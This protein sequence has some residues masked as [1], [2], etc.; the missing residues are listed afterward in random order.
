MKQQKSI[1]GIALRYGSY[2]LI[3]T[4]VVLAVL[5][6]VN[7]AAGLLPASYTSL[8]VS[9]QDIYAISDTSRTYMKALDDKVTVYVV[10]SDSAVD[11]I[12][13]EYVDRYSDL[14]AKLSVKTVD[15]VLFPNFVSGYV[16]EAFDSA[17]TNLLVVNEENGRARLILNNEIYYQQYSKE[18]LNY[19]YMMYGQMPDNPTYFNI[20]NELLSAIDYVS[21][22]RLPTVY[23]TAGHGEFALD[24]SVKK[25]FDK[26]N[27]V[28]NE[29][30][31][32]T[33]TEVPI[34][35]SLVLIYAPTMDFTEAELDLLR[36]Y[37][38]KGGHIL[39]ISYDV[40]QTTQESDDTTADTDE[41]PE[42]GADTEAPD[43]GE[44]T[45]T[46]EKFANLYRFAAEY[47]LMH[48]KAL[49]LEGDSA[50][51]SSYY[52]PTYIH[53]TLTSHP[54]AAAVPSNTYVL[55]GYAHG[56]TVQDSLSGVT[57]TKL[58]TTTTKAYGKTLIDKNTTVEKQEG[59]IE[60]QFILAAKSDK[61]GS[62]GTSSFVWF[63][64]PLMLDAGTIGSYSNVSY[65]MAVVT[66]LCDKEASITVN[67][68]SLQVAALSIS[69]SAAN[70]WSVILIG[71]IPAAMLLCGFFLWRRRSTR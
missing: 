67:S 57:V 59:D 46:P 35:A 54:Y 7:L 58:M 13:Y 38:D 16:E 29:L 21:M 62:K 53:A 64:S 40:P 22:E 24:D 8:S 33:V 11:N 49:V 68:P 17:T 3:V 50:H 28:L 55:M 36:T 60:G 34:D 41:A 70:T 51:Y 15:P 1:G 37:A 44:A 19:Y 10:A 18:E 56:I 5:I 43:D 61:I 48:Q 14:S 47:G 9:G 66:D 32:S 31:L 69:D 65:L 4:A 6:L 30:K 42:T 20:E 2:S 45:V 52:G 12:V 26:D 71:I 63:A 39:L 25:L 27:I 23:Y